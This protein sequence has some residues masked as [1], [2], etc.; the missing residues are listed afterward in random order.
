MR[1]ESA[2]LKFHHRSKDGSGEIRTGL[3]TLASPLSNATSCGGLASI[4][5]LTYVDIHG[6]FHRMKKRTT[7]WLPDSLLARLKNL[8]R[9]TGAPMAEL[10]RRAV[11]AYLK[12]F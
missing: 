1:A 4:I 12:R 6:R 3:W 9:K 5:A 8:S 11:E 7:V 10:F 2:A